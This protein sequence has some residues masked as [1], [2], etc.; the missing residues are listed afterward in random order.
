M[1]DSIFLSKSLTE[2]FGLNVSATVKDSFNTEGVN[3]GQKIIIEPAGIEST[4]SF[5]VELTLG[6]RTLSAV[7]RPADYASTLLKKMNHSNQ[8]QRTAF[9]VFADSLRSK[10]AV[11]DLVINDESFDATD[12]HSWP[13]KWSEI[14]FKMK[15]I[16]LVL[17]KETEYDFSEAFPWT[18]GF[19]GMTLAL[20]PLEE[21]SGSEITGEVE[22]DQF[23][24]RVKRY[25]RSRINRA[26]CIEVNGDSCKICG[27]SFG[28]TYGEHGEGF[29]HV[30]HIIPMS[31][32]SE[33]YYLN[34]A[35]DLIPV[36]PNCHS[37][38]HRRKKVL[39][40]EGLKNIIT[41]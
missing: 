16:G 12:P 17:E 26:A 23:F 30:H 10:G 27:F 33:S 41:A 9:S 34:P 3:D 21:I 20:L 18:T 38:L 22:G 13:D 37:M 31:Q 6:W 32:M 11:I 28:G 25:E 8:E 19:F 14:N 29:I 2:R 36:C 40:P 24:E 35:K 15:K 1:I 39:L 4:I 5:K 7:F